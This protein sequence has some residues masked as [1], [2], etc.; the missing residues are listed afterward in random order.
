MILIA[1]QLF[2]WNYAIPLKCRVLR[3]EKWAAVLFGCQSPDRLIQIQRFMGTRQN[4]READPLTWRWSLVFIIWYIIP[5]FAGFHTNWEY[6]Q[7]QAEHIQKCPYVS[8]SVRVGMKSG[9]NNTLFS[10]K[11]RGRKHEETHHKLILE[12]RWRSRWCEAR[13]HSR[14]SSFFSALTLAFQMPWRGD[15][16]LWWCWQCWSWWRGW[17]RCWWRCWWRWWPAGGPVVTEGSLL[18]GLEEGRR[19]GPWCHGPSMGSDPIHP[20]IRP[21]SLAGDKHSCLEKYSW[22][23]GGNISERKT[24]IALCNKLY[25]CS[26]GEWKWHTTG[27][28]RIAKGTTDWATLALFLNKMLLQHQHLH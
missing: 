23:S 2:V 25:V 14:P 27:I 16:Q 20:T 7:L 22:K 17:R 6:Q 9:I 26:H 5:W 11:N 10:S 19:P 4:W 21:T 1:S 24:W 15:W 3:K 8:Q 12:G 18:E 13:S 28:Q